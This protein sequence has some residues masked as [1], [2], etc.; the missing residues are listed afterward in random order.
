MPGADIDMAL[1]VGERLRDAVEG[2]CIAHASSPEGQVTIS[3][4]V[5]SLVPGVGQDAEHL[6][7]AADIALYAAKRRGR[8][9]VVAHGRRRAGGSELTHRFNSKQ[10][11]P[12]A[13]SQRGQGEA[14]DAHR[15]RRRDG[16]QQQAKGDNNRLRSAGAQV[17]ATA[18]RPILAGKAQHETSHDGGEEQRR[19]IRRRR[20]RPRRGGG[21]KHQQR[22]QREGSSWRLREFDVRARG[23]SVARSD[24]QF[25][26]L[27]SLAAV[28]YFI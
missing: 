10:S 16:R 24:G 4:G 25:R 3:I 7:E 26:N 20:R 17:S 28:N 18:P 11:Q 27:C 12:A 8:N 9:A 6:V 13:C 5:A 19:R 15:D 23:A 2:L 1:K 22:G 14:I 21:G